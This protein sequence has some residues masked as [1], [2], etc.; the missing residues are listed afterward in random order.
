CAKGLTSGYVPLGAVVVS[1]EIAD[2]LETNMLWT[3]LTF[4]G[5][6]VS[7][8]AALATL[9]FYEEA[10]VFANVEEQGAHLGRRLEALKAKYRCVGDVRYKGL[11]S[12]IELVRDK[13]T[14]E[15]LAPF[16][17]TSPEM[18]KL[19]GYLKSKHVYAFS[20]FNMVWVCPPLVITREE[21]KYGLDIYEEALALVDQM[22]G[23]VAAD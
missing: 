18:Q 9:E 5:H 17:G 12:M 23:A 2:Y 16:N 19:T 14:K 15:P 7:C 21:L 1:R 8:A 13:A 3:G 4:S 6:P 11:F 10:G 22:L 20:R